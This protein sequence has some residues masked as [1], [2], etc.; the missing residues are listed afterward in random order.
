MFVC[1]TCF[2]KNLH[3]AYCLMSSEHYFSYQNMQDENRFYDILIQHRNDGM[4]GQ[5]GQRLLNATR[6]QGG[7]DRDENLSVVTTTMHPLFS[8]IYKRRSM[9][10][11]KNFTHHGRR[12]SFSYYILT[13]LHREATSYPPPRHKLSSSVCLI[14]GNLH[15]YLILSRFS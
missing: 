14:T 12:S 4:M 2:W 3:H 15:Q 11:S 10:L 5:L 6:K 9:A 1:K 7:L 8:E 13:I